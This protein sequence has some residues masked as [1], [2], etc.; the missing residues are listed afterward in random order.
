MKATV[1]NPVVGEPDPPYFRTRGGAGDRDARGPGI[2][3]FGTY[4]WP[5]FLGRIGLGVKLR[6]AD[7]KVSDV[8][9]L[10]TPEIN[11]TSL[12]FFLSV[13]LID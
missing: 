5:L 8:E 6:W 2:S 3:A 10:I 4:E 11:L 1:T 7:L 9:G 12:T 13:L